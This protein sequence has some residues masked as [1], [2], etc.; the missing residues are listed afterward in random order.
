MPWMETDAM[1]QR[2]EFVVRARQPDACFAAL[3]RQ[4]GVSRRV[5]YKWLARARD[6]ERL[7]DLQEASRR[8]HH[9]PARIA[10]AIEQRIVALR[11]LDGWGGRKIRKL[12]LEEGI[13]LARRTVDRVIRR[14]G[15]V[16]PERQGRSAWRR[17]ERAAPNEL[18]QMDFKG[19]YRI[20][21]R[22][23]FPWAV[24]DD[25][26]RFLIGLAPLT[27]TRTAP[28]WQVLR[29]SFEEYGVPAAFLIDRG[30]PW[31]GT[32]NGHGLTRLSVQLIKQGC[33]LIPG[34]PRHP[35]THG[36][37]ERFNRTLDEWLKHRD[38]LGRLAGLRP[39]FREFRRRYNEIR[40]HEALND[41]TPQQHYRPSERRFRP[42][43][44]AW[45]YPPGAVVRRLNPCGV[46]C[47]RGHQYFVCEALAR[48]DV[49]CQPFEDR[50]L[51]TYRQMHIREID[52]RTG[53][54]YPI[55]R[56]SGAEAGD[57]PARTSRSARGPR[58]QVMA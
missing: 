51:V 43:P 54:T 45:D 53:A 30:A 46:L 58:G 37:I 2:I 7:S 36:K 55:L 31:W 21:G 24:L 26:S 33:E 57:L 56:P 48:E 35:Q 39:G 14:Q 44:P 9:S 5:G 34:R 18:W 47:Y 27:T 28:V 40:P 16:A 25:H 52:L 32:T 8:P 1:D 41:D 4:F 19:Q 12:L 49:W 10:P 20:E 6:A 29:Y 23:I 3:C 11:G 38:L 17:F 13:V 50:V 22:E 42:R 15:L